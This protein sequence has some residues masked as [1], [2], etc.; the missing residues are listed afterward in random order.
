MINLNQANKYCSDDVSLIENYNEAINSDKQY[1]CHHKNGITLNKSITEL[2]EL[3]LYFNRP[4]NELIFL[5]ISEHKRLHMGCNNPS[6]NKDRS[7]ENNPMYGKHYKHTKESINKI[8]VNHAKSIPCIVN[9]NRYNS[10]LLAYKDIKPNCTYNQFIYKVHK[11]QKI[12]N[13]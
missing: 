11:G 7:G 12:F 4:A 8:T 13:N 9:G 5:E 2:K 6:K 1:V 10:I 3:G